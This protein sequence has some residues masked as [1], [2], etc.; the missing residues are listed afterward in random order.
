ML[1]IICYLVLRH[2]PINHSSRC[3]ADQVALNFRENKISKTLHNKYCCIPFL[4][5]KHI[6]L[7]DRLETISAQIHI[8]RLKTEME[9]LFIKQPNKIRTDDNMANYHVCVSLKVQTIIYS[10]I[11]NI[12]VLYFTTTLKKQPTKCL[13]SN[14]LSP[15]RAQ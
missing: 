10:C 14:T 6:S 9:L 2:A 12:A 8:N 13:S 1:R 7:D 11:L 5:N 4:N 3:Q 15:Y